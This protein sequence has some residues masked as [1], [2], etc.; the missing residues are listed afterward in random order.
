M[1]KLTGVKVTAHP[2]PERGQWEHK[3]PEKGILK[4]SGAASPVGKKVT[5]AKTERQSWFVQ[6]PG[7]GEWTTGEFPWGNRLAGGYRWRVKNE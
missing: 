5:I 6:Y 2:Y 3:T 1:F 7:V 4:K